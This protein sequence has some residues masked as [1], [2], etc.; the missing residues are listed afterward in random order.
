[1]HVVWPTFSKDSKRSDPLYWRAQQEK[2]KFQEW[3]QQKSNRKCHE[4]RWDG[5]KESETWAE[6]QDWVE[7]AEFAFIKQKICRTEIIL[8]NCWVRQIITSIYQRLKRSQ[9]KEYRISNDAGNKQVSLISDVML[10][11][12]LWDFN[13]MGKKEKYKIAT[14]SQMWPRI[15]FLKVVRKKDEECW[16]VKCLIHFG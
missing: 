9:S 3:Q 7:K 8:T 14:G 16:E 6:G 4:E 15:V 12:V 1:M 2:T 11:E 5:F 13:I 10:G